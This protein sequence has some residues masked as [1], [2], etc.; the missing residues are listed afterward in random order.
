MQQVNALMLDTKGACGDVNRNV[1]TNVN[2]HQSS[3]HAEVYQISKAIS[4]HLCWQSG[5]Y[6]EIWLGENVSINRENLKSRFTVIA[7][8]RVNLKSVSLFH[9]K[10]TAMYWPMILL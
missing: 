1:V 10:T 8:Y 3:V 5:A 7:I 4:D 6:A 2:P 9:L